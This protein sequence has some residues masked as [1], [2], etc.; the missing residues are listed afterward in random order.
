MLLDEFVPH[1]QFVERHAITIPRPRDDV[2]QVL[3]QVDFGRSHL[4][5]MLF[6][7]RGLGPSFRRGRSR[8]RLRLDDFVRAGF[9]LLADQPGEETVYGVAS[10]VTGRR[11][12]IRPLDP[13]SFASL[14]QPGCMK[15]VLNFRLRSLDASSTLVTTETRV[16]ATDEPARRA[17]ARYWM[18]VGPFSAL[19][20]RRMLAVLRT[21]CLAD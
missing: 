19:I 20:R 6:A 2:Y 14:D 4:I 21:E 1:Y 12:G 18:I 3:R 8:M 10:R 9:T 17:F 5:R 16:F 13:K 15:A 7:L 11:R